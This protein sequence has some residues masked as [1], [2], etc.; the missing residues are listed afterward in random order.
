VDIKMEVPI[1][2]LGTIEDSE[3]DDRLARATPT[4][5]PINCS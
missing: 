4:N 1:D 3:D 2:D 5:Q